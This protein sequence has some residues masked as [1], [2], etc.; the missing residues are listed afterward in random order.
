M[1]VRLSI[2][3]YS[4]L[5]LISGAR[6]PDAG[7]ALYLYLFWLTLISGTRGPDAGTALYLYLFWLTLI[8][9]ARGAD[10]RYIYYIYSGLSIFIP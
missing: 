9:G 10:A 7:T 5:T 1:R 3:I 2:Y 8:S 6:G 4:G